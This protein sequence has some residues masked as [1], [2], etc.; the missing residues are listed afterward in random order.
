MIITTRD[1]VVMNAHAAWTLPDNFT[2]TPFRKVIIPEKRNRAIQ[3]LNPELNGRH[4]AD[5]VFKSWLKLLYFYLNP[6]HFL[7]GSIDKK[8]HS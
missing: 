2:L 8:R 7:N 3:E 1:S 4:I 5:D 6:L